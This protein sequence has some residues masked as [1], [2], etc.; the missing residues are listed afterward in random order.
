MSLEFI[1]LFNQNKTAFVSY[2]DRNPAFALEG[3]IKIKSTGFLFTGIKLKSKT[4][5]EGKKYFLEFPVDAKGNGTIIPL[6]PEAYAT[7]LNL[8]IKAMTRIHNMSTAEYFNLKEADAATP[9][10]SAD[11]PEY[12]GDIQEVNE[13]EDTYFG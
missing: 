11:I 2:P 8:A 1:P 3:F 9:P 6:T 4:T 7:V 13:V 12:T 5:D 10:D